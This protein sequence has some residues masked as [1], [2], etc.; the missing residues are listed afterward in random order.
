MQQFWSWRTAVI[1]LANHW[2]AVPMLRPSQKDLSLPSSEIP[3]WPTRMRAL[4]RVGGGG[5]TGLAAGI[6]PVWR[7]VGWRW[8]GA[9][10]IAAVSPHGPVATVHLKVPRPLGNSPSWTVAGWIISRRCR[11]TG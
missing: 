6:T 2:E 9:A 1:G 3:W 4:L 7:Q 10:G 11:L 5:G 8:I